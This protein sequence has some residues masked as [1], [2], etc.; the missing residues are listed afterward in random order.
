MT[1]DDVAHRADRGGRVDERALHRTGGG[2]GQQTSRGLQ[3][4]TGPAQ[5]EDEIVR[6]GRLRGFPVAQ[7]QGLG[8]GG[9]EP[10]E[11]AGGGRT[12]R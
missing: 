2:G 3:G 4:I 11:V 7:P 10:V 1:V 8:E 6:H 5:V 9:E 12:V